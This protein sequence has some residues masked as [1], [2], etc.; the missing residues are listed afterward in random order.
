[1]SGASVGAGG[2]WS[3][4]TSSVAACIGVL[5][6]VV[7]FP[8]LLWA[9]AGWPLPHGVPD[10]SEASAA[11]SDG[12]IP[13]RLWI[14]LAALVG[15][16]VWAQLGVAVLAEVVAAARR[17]EASAL[18]LVASPARHLARRLVGSA[19]MVGAL[20]SPRVALAHP[21]PPPLAIAADPAPLATAADSAPVYVVQD[22]DV[23]RDCLWTI[24]ERHLDDG[25]R[26]R[27]IWELNRGRPQPDGDVLEKADVIRPGW[28]LTL[29]A[30]ATGLPTQRPAPPALAAD[31]AAAADSAPT[32]PAPT[33]SVQTTL[34]ADVG[35]GAAAAPDRVPVPVPAPEAPVE[36]PMVDAGPR[37]Q[38]VPPAPTTPGA[39]A[40]PA[41]AP[42][43]KE[44]AGRGLRANAPNLLG[45]GLLAAGVIA[46]LDR[47]RRAQ[48]RRRRPGQRI[49]LPTADTARHEWAAREGADHR[50]AELFDLAVRAMAHGLADAGDVPPEIAAFEL[51]GGRLEVVLATP[52]PAPA[53]FVDDVVDGRPRWVLVA[54]GAE[55]LRWAA[56][57][58]HPLPAVVTL[59]RTP[60]GAQVL[61]DLVEPCLT[62]IA[63][64]AE[65]GRELVWAAAAEMANRIDD[66]LFSLC[67]VGFGDELASPARRV[68]VLE[69]FDRALDY[70]ESAGLAGAEELAAGGFASA[71]HAQVATGQP[72]SWGP[73]VVLCDRPPPA[74]QLERLVRL[75]SSA[76]VANVAVLVV[77]DAPGAARQLR[78]VD[79]LLE[80]PGLDERIEPQRLSAAEAAAIGEMFEVGRHR[81]P[82]HLYPEP[83]VPPVVDLVDVDEPGLLEVVT[84]PEVASEAEPEAVEE[85]PAVVGP[86]LSRPEVLVRVLGPVGVELAGQPV[87]FARMKAVEALAYLV[88]HRGLAI[89]GDRLGEALWPKSE[90]R[91]TG[92][93]NTT[94]WEV[95]DRLGAMARQALEGNEPA[96]KNVD[97]GARFLAPLRGARRLY[98]P[99]EPVGLDYDL[100]VEANR[101]AVA[102]DAA[103]MA[104]LRDAL[105]LVRGRPF[106]TSASGKDEG[107]LW[108]LVDGL[109]YEMAAGVVDA[110][111]R[112][113]ELCLQ[114]GDLG[115]ARWAAGRGMA[116]SPG[117]EVLC[118][119]RMRIAAAAGSPAG[120]DAVMDELRTW[121]GVD[122]PCDTELDP[123]TVALY[124]KL[125]PHPLDRR[126]RVGAGR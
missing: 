9:L 16:L 8:V 37:H 50:G 97:Y 34:P 40:A 41:A 57:V 64:D 124:R 87:A 105:E 113:V 112:L 96:R 68:E 21:P 67:L 24:A 1:M 94:L 78:V 56:E 23:S 106:E 4:V 32:S 118:R 89:D 6:L 45:G 36:E 98:E 83:L 43:A 49:P 72:D 111:H 91:P 15:W 2:R 54:G 53:G 20:V 29:P 110:A 62:T 93:L 99:G 70:I 95:R 19:A 86:T 5:A 100:V 107:F 26:W 61:V 52:A 77:G 31:T 79:G 66:M 122:Q 51:D 116:A 126:P 85:P 69:S 33:T 48:M 11:I 101:L 38:A 14:G 74:E 115:G 73:L 17:Q 39:E 119:D 108:A 55:E 81:S 82:S 84:S 114:A 25:R 63:G 103:A 60:S 117:N 76:A 3:R 10:W 44:S 7:G 12:A 120:V 104:A 92:N 125:R 88:T 28:R 27:E 58:P 121:V 18:P 109:L 13:D 102:G 123:E 46:T 59:G 35:A 22:W 90:G 65:V 42:P 75:T 80:V 47:L 71:L 30:D